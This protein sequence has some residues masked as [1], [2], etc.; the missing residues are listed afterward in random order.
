[1]PR[2]TKGLTERTTFRFNIAEQEM[3][4]RMVEDQQT[5]VNDALRWALRY[6]YQHQHTTR[7]ARNSPCISASQAVF[8]RRAQ[9]TGPDDTA[10]EPEQANSEDIAS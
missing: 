3:L 4:D 6:A 1:M 7:C 10:L 2:P 5:T 9:V 8:G